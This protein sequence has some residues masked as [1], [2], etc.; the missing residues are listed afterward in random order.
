MINIDFKARS[1][2]DFLAG[3][4]RLASAAAV[5]SLASTPASAQSTTPTKQPISTG[6]WDLR[7]LDI[8][9][10]ATDRAVFDWP[11]LGDPTDPIVLEIAE[12]YLDGCRA[13]Y[14]PNSYDARVVLNIRSQAV[15]AALSDPLWEK[16]S[17]GTE[18]NVK[19]P[20][21]NKPA[22]RNPFWHRAPS[23]VPGIQLPTGADLVDR[24]AIVLACDFALG[25]LATRLASKRGGSV[26]EIHQD[27]RKGLVSGGY[28]VPSGIFGLARAQ[29]AGCAY[30]RM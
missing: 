8:L 20:T 21:T 29:N 5:T 14:Q 9:K 25:H 13:V 15:S 22:T 28:A 2:R 6:D 18:Y 23:S 24:G 27:L 11:S 10:P 3:A 1:R 7:W 26:D 16:Y 12:R 19:D 4:G 17:L 30:V